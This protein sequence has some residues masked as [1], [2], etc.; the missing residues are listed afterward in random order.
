MRKSPE[1]KAKLMRPLTSVF[2]HEDDDSGAFCDERL[3]LFHLL[4]RAEG[5]V[6]CPALSG[7]MNQP[8]HVRMVGDS[9]VGRT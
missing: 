7:T 1:E 5:E 8:C 3:S 2:G 4:M 6:V 9:E